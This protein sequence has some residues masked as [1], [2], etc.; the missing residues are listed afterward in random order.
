MRQCVIFDMDGVII[1]SEPVHIACEKEIIRLLGLHIPEQEH[2]AFIGTTDEIM[3]SKIAE[4]HKLPINVPYII[5]LKKSLYMEH[6]KKNNHLSP[7]SYIS[8]LI[9]NLHR[10]KFLLAL[11]SSS[12]HEQI[13]YILNTFGIRDYFQSVVSGE[14]VKVGKPDPEIFMKAAELLNV[15]AGSCVVIE[16]SYNGVTAAKSANMKCIGFKN[17]NSGN[18]DLSN[19]DRI[20][21]S[22]RE[23][24]LDMIREL[25][26]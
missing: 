17:P 15:S 12:P 8:E 14:D 3:W 6:L 22:F 11:A 20:V 21:H 25:L 24:S 7:V 5:Q 2:H 4:M 18:Q 26:I 9:A 23:I 13:D 19:A 16:D 10:N 1:D